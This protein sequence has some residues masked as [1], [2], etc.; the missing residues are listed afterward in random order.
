MLTS[1]FCPLTLKLMSPSPYPR[2]LFRQI[3]LYS[4]QA[5]SIS[6]LDYSRILPFGLHNS[7]LSLFLF[8][9]IFFLFCCA[10]ALYTILFSLCYSS[11]YEPPLDYERLPIISKFLCLSPK[12]SINWLYTIHPVSYQ[13]SEWTFIL[14]IAVFLLPSKAHSSF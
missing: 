2:T 9:P 12:T 14:V 7:N 13:F 3:H 4:F 10:I 6:W 1:A 5:L 8:I 11:P